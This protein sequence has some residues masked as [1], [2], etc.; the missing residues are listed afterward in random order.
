MVG[1]RQGGDRS[2]ALTEL[3]DG[4]VA[5]DRADNR[6]GFTL[7]WGRGDAGTFIIERANRTVTEI[8]VSRSRGAVQHCHRNS[9]CLLPR[10]PANAS[11][12]G[13]AI[14]SKSVPGL[15]SESARIIS[16]RGSL[17]LQNNKRTLGVGLLARS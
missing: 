5:T 3:P 1:D 16:K 17:F 12:A 14:R 10:R 2:L 6:A 13:D 15:S 9:A 8:I 4:L 11:Q 7:I